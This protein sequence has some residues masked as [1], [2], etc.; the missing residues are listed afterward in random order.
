MKVRLGE[1]E[2]KSVQF[3]A[4]Q[5]K[6]FFELFAL[7]VC[8]GDCFVDGNIKQ[9]SYINFFTVHCICQCAQFL[10]NRSHGLVK[11][12]HFVAFFL[13]PFNRGC[14]CIA[15]RAG[16]AGD[17]AVRT[18]RKAVAAGGAFVRVPDGVLETDLRHVAIDAGACRNQAH[19]V[20]WIRQVVVWFSVQVEMSG[21]FP[22]AM[23]ICFRIGALWNTL[24]HNRKF[25]GFPDAG[26]GCFGNFLLR[27][28]FHFVITATDNANIVVDDALSFAAEFFL[29]LILNRAEQ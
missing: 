6:F 14:E 12:L 17:G 5:F 22:E 24:E 28:F 20:E 4:E 27:D 2:F 13:D 19:R 18:D 1:G 21:L 23:D 16:E 29:Q 9:R 11:N 10:L 8:A 7:A 26:S 3:V 15:V 25:R